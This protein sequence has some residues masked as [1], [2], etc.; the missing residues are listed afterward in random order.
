MATYEITGTLPKALVGQLP[1]AE[2]ITRFLEDLLRRMSNDGTAN[3]LDALV[4]GLPKQPNE[5]E[6]IE[7]NFFN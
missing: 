2:D 1:P 3:Y 5:T 4:N 6:W 7:F